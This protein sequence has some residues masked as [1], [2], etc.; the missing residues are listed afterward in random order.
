MCSERVPVPV[1]LV[2]VLCLM[3]AG[4]NFANTR[5]VWPEELSDGD[6]IVEQL[7][8]V[9]KGYRYDKTPIKQILIHTDAAYTGKLPN[10]GQAE[11]VGCPVSQCWLTTDKS[12]GSV[13]DAVLFVQ[14]YTRPEFQ[15]PSEQVSERPHR[16]TS[17]YETV[18]EKNFVVGDRVSLAQN[19]HLIF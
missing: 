2:Y 17:I 1:V 6:R 15:R 9:P 19:I 12:L 8:Y 3:S 16:V 18:T 5:L 11:L 7:S 14:N 4:S 10:L 13:A